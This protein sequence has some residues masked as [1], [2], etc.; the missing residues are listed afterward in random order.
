MKLRTPEHRSGS[1]LPTSQRPRDAWRP[2]AEPGRCTQA[3][4]SPAWH[5]ACNANV[6]GIRVR[7]HNVCVHGIRHRNQ[8]NATVDK[9]AWQ[10]THPKV[11]YPPPTM[12]RR[13][14]R[15]TV[16]VH[17]DEPTMPTRT[18]TH[19]KTQRQKGTPTMSRR[20]VRHNTP[21]R[22][23]KTDAWGTTQTHMD[24]HACQDKLPNAYK[25]HVTPRHPNNASTEPLGAPA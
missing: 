20:S 8:R 13:S 17:P 11:V 14:V 2:T 7:Q 10:N 3:N 1:Y 22:T 18:K 23:N 21:R 16:I 25:R 6:I 15:R 24:K 5:Q 12:S 4:I 9:H 19:G